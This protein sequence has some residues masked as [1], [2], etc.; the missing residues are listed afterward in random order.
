LVKGYM[1]FRGVPGHEFV[2]VVEQA[3][4]AEEWEGRRVVGDINAA[5]GDC[6]TCRAGRPTHCP[7]RTTLGIEGRD[8]AFAEYLTL[9]VRNLLPVP[10]VLPDEVAVFT[11]PLAAACEILQQVHVHPTDHV[12]VLGDGKLGLLCAQVLALTGC[13][14][15]AIGHHQDK[16]DI[17]ARQ[18]IHTALGDTSV[19]DGADIVIES[20]GHPGGY[21][22]ARRLVRPR[23]TVVLK[24]T[25]HGAVDADLTMAVVDE[26]TLVGS[27]CGPFGPALRLLERGLVEVIPLI[28]AR[29]P[30]SEGL[31]AFEHAVRPGTLKVLIDVGQAL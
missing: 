30:L 13:D 26:V 21:A 12:V 24:S 19:A 23:G 9:P 2:G 17:L 3:P 25:Y 22:A 31:T 7:H 1:R 6:P 29:Y 10:D 4:G 14:L 16:L 20:T 28:Q 8:G 15:I 11:E 18:G 5:C 27:R